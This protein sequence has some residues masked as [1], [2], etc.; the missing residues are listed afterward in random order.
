VSSSGMKEGTLTSFPKK[1]VIPV[2]M[3]NH[4]SL[5][6]VYNAAQIAKVDKKRWCCSE[7]PIYF[8]LRSFG[9]SFLKPSVPKCQRLV[10]CRME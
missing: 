5:C 6:A 10:K 7:N 1:I 4:W 9:F 8:V 2:N 3:D